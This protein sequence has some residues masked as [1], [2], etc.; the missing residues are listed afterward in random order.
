MADRIKCWTSFFFFRV[1]VNSRLCFHLRLIYDFFNPTNTCLLFLKNH[2]WNVN[3]SIGVHLQPLEKK[4]CSTFSSIFNSTLNYSAKQI[5]SES[6]KIRIHNHL[7]QK[8]TSIIQPIW[9]NDW[10]IVYEVSGC[11]FNSRYCHLNFKYC[12][13]FCKTFLNIHATKECRSTLKRVHDMIITYSTIN[14]V[15]NNCV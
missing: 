8:Q 12:V 13:Y 15:Q 9:L 3:E 2:K 6:N 4:S 1:V 11:G 7:V 5:L 14:F 10:V